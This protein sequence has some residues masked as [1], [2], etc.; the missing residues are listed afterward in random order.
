VGAM[1]ALTGQNC[2]RGTKLKK[3]I[4]LRGSG[5]NCFF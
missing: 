3:K 5:K 4:K 1:S 2:A